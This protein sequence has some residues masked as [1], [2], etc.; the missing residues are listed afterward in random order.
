MYNINTLYIPIVQ[1]LAT[2]TTLIFPLNK[3]YYIPGVW[4][5]RHQL[6]MFQAPHTA[7]VGCADCPATGIQPGF[8]GIGW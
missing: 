5:A 4:Q 1:V 3:P 2:G 7:V 8:T 6:E